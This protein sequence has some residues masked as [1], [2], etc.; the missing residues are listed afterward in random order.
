MPRDACHPAHLLARW[1]AGH[2]CN[3]LWARDCCS[4]QV[5]GSPGFQGL[6]DRL[7]FV[8]SKSQPVGPVSVASCLRPTCPP[9]LHKLFC[10]G[11]RKFALNSG[12]F[13]AAKL[14]SSRY[15]NRQAC[16]LA[17]L[18]HSIF[19]AS[20]NK[21]DIPAA[22]GMADS[23]HWRGNPQ[24]RA[25][26]QAAVGGTGVLLPVTLARRQAM[27]PKTA[28]RLPRWY[29]VKTCCVVRQVVARRRMTATK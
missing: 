14:L 26:A 15:S 16:S 27:A 4:W 9:S 7:Q 28:S 1:V 19:C 23:E 22:V 20:S 2:R 18:P 12:F 8:G 21:G 6:C 29:L 17:C 13:P 24:G 10:P 5:G 11:R 25:V 3:V